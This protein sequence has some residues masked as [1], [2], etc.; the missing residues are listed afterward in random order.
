[1]HGNS[2][3][4]PPCTVRL[5]TKQLEQAQKIGLCFFANSKSNADIAKIPT[6]LAS[7]EVPYTHLHMDIQWSSIK[8]S[9]SDLIPL[10]IYVKRYRPPK[11]N[12]FLYRVVV[13][14][15]DGKH[16]SLPPGS[17]VLLEIHS[18]EQFEGLMCFCNNSVTEA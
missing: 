13:E 11:L 3:L 1:M 7:T 10:K 2:V 18:S 16:F 6:D 14:N 5:V 12:E 8:S 15:S 17:F 4:L 9:P